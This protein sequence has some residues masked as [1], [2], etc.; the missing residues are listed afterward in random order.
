MSSNILQPVDEVRTR[1]T[2]DCCN[3]I[4]LFQNE[5]SKENQAQA[6]LL[7]LEIAA[8]KER[9]AEK[10]KL[11]EKLMNDLQQL[12]EYVNKLKKKIEEFENKVINTKMNVL[13]V[14]ETI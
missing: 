9:M 2:T 11:T 4:C 12:G 6:E 8:L 3:F 5:L 7:K 14:L 1:K 13:Q 10:D